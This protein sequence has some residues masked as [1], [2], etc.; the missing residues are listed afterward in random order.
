MTKD[1]A[2]STE[3]D[4]EKTPT[5]QKRRTETAKPT[6]G[7]APKPRRSIFDASYA[8]VGAEL[9]KAWSPHSRKS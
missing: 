2:H 1:I 3:A 5:T 8:P 4:S 6:M 7:E 9:R